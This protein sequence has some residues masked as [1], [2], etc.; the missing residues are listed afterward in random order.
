MDNMWTCHECGQKFLHENQNHSCNE[1]TVDSFFNGK[2]DS[3]L[4]LFQYFIQEYQKI[5]GFV[6]HPAKSRIAFAAKIRFGY[7]ARVGKDFIDIALTFNK[8]YRDNLCFYRI[9]EAPGGKIFQHYIRLKHKDDVNDEVRRFM[10]VALQVGNKQ[11]I[12]E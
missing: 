11:P 7:I 3:V 8:A 12:T 10:R 5:G 9:G 2:S 6:L 1:R 4:E